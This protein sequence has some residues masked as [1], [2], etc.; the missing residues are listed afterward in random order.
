MNPTAHGDDPDLFSLLGIWRDLDFSEITSQ[1]VEN[2]VPTLTKSSY[3]LP[4]AATNTAEEQQ[5]SY[6]DPV[7]HPGRQS[8]SGLDSHPCSGQQG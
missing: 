2:R 4:A 8:K 7:I 1:D 6:L 3:R 5:R